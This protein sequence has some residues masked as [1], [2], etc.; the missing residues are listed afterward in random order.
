MIEGVLQ[1]IAIVLGLIALGGIF[2]AAEIALISLRESQV[3]QIA[4]K[5]KRGAR[6]FKLS[7]NPNRF[8]A[9]VQVGIT[10]CGF[11]SAALGAEQ[12]GKYVIPELEGVGISSQYSEIISIVAITLVIAYI[13]LVFGELVPKRL[14]LYKSESIA[15]ATAST[16]DFVAT[17]FRPIIWLLSHSTDLI[18]KIFG[19]NSKMQQNQISEVELMELVSGHADLTKEER[20]IVEEVFNASD[21]LIHEIMVP[22]TE[23][24][25]LDASLSISQARKMAVELAHSRYPVVRGS[26]DEVIGFLHVRDLL[27]PKLDDAQITIMELIRDILFLPGTKGVLPALTEMQTKR[28]HI[29]IVLDEYGGTDGIVTLENLVECLIGEIHDEYDPHEADKS[30]EKRTGDIE[31]DGLISLEELQEVSGILLPEG[32]YETLSGFFM[33]NLG[34]IAQANDVIKING[35][36]FTIVSMNGKRVGQI[37]LAKDGA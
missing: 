3:K 33:H 8:L 17:I 9:A 16:L 13:S 15:L 22:R 20:E 7:K 21:R 10:L 28:Q 5:G 27:N 26:S 19:I 2:A 34:R 31:L 37:L 35:A 24:D 18:L 23:V 6:V 1:S 25:F 29:A 30:F 14:A 32:P 36:R 4:V 12:L 11:L